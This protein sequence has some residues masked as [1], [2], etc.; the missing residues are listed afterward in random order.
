MLATWVDTKADESFSDTWNSRHAK[1]TQ[2]VNKFLATEG[3][4]AEKT[5]AWL[6]LSQKFP[7][8]ATSSALST[9]ASRLKKTFLSPFKIAKVS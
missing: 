5:P 2:R 9:S 1:K 6:R 4:Q 3:Y 7:A 8:P